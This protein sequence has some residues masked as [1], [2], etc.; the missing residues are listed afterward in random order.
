MYVQCW[1]SVTDPDSDQSPRIRTSN[2]RI[3]MQIREAQKHTDPTD[4]D[5]DAV[6][7]HWYIYII[8]Q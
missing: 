2:Y 4:S 5:Q 3:R 1:G 6:S 7:E 8:L